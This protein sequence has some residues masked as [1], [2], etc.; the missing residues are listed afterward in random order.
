MSYFNTLA[1]VEFGPLMLGM[2][3]KCST[4]V[5]LGSNPDIYEL[6]FMM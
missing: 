4:I 6:G 2:G 5:L 1:L 3:A